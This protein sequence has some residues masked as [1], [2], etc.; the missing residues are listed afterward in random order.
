MHGTPVP[1]P[2]YEQVDGIISAG[3]TGQGEG[4]RDCMEGGRER[5]TG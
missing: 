5:E 3:Y 4:G 2:V 1:S